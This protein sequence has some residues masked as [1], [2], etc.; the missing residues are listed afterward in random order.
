MEN[1][2]QYFNANKELWNQRT[3]IHKDSSFYDVAGFK[4]GKNVL[5]P[6]ELNEMG[7]VTGKKMLHLQCHFGLD[8]LN[9]RRLGADVTGVDLSDAAIKEAKKLNNELGLN[10]K[11]ICCNIYDLHPQLIEPSKAPPLEGF[12][13]ADIVFTSYGVIGWLP[14]LDKWAEIISYYLKPG[15]IF[16]L[17]EFHPVLWMF[18][19]EFTHVKY[20]YNNR[21]V[22][23]TDSQGTYTDRTANIKTKEYS[24]NHSLS[25]VLNAPIS[26]DLRIEQ[27]NEFMYSPYPCFNNMVQGEDGNWRIKG[28]EEKMPMVYSVKVL[29]Q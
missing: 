9:W 25:E 16:C 1:N 17:A 12:G 11:F 24:W 8:S 22:I 29:K 3:A 10:A 14:D 21:E 27:F 6:I 28:M 7:D 4:A 15:G 23:V 19:E 20:Y 26:H 13:E 5:T 2:D 18:D